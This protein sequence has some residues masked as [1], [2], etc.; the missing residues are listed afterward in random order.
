MILIA[1]SSFLYFFLSRK[2]SLI[3]LK[4]LFVLPILFSLCLKNPYCNNVEQQKCFFIFKALNKER[5]IAL[6]VWRRLDTAFTLHSIRACF[7]FGEVRLHPSQVLWLRS[8]P[9]H[10]FYNYW[11]NTKN[12]WQMRYISLVC[13]AD[14]GKQVMTKGNNLIASGKTGH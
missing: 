3:I 1:F 14:G 10:I 5:L 12:C 8:C 9:T 13:L 11:S 4:I 7:E 6:A 2:A